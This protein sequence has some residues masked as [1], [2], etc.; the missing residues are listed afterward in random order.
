MCTS[1]AHTY[2][3]TQKHAHTHTH[4]F[5]LIIMA[6][7]KMQIFVVLFLLLFFFPALRIPFPSSV[8]PIFSVIFI[9]IL[10]I[11]V[12]FF[13]TTCQSRRRNRTKEEVECN[14]SPICI[15]LLQS[16][17]PRSLLRY[18]GGISIFLYESYRARVLDIR[19]HVSEQMI[20][21]IKKKKNEHANVRELERGEEAFFSDEGE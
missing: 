16:L 6:D 20:R 5:I 11:I 19:K 21:E 18:F 2:I 13:R 7:R 14:Q 15:Y 8:F 4:T 1:F 10:M 9:F 3:H 12:F 17:V